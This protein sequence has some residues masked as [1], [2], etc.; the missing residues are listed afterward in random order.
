MPPK[1]AAPTAVNAVSERLQLRHSS[2]I[3][4]RDL[5]PIIEQDVRRVGR[6]HSGEDL[7]LV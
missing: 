1:P 6:A 4:E 2:V 7:I 3:A 5:G